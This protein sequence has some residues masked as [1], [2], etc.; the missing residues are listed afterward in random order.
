MGGW[1]PKRG[2]AVAQ[3]GHPIP[4]HIHSSVSMHLGVF[5]GVFTRTRSSKYPCK[6]WIQSTFFNQC[7]RDKGRVQSKRQTMATLSSTDPGNR[8]RS[9]EPQSSLPNF[10]RLGHDDD[11]RVQGMRGWSGIS[12]QPSSHLNTT[13]SF[14]TVCFLFTFTVISRLI[15]HLNDLKNVNHNHLQIDHIQHGVQDGHF[16]RSPSTCPGGESAPRYL[17]HAQRNCKECAQVVDGVHA[18][19]HV[20]G[21]FVL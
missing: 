14:P 2:R 16:T 4:W 3:F 15:N 18:G 13:R 20:Q 5:L 9:T 6:T 7:N 11:K 12:L 10:A 17:S 8:I 1:Q 19:G 21:R